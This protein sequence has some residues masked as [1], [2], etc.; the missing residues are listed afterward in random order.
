MVLFYQSAESK[1]PR[2][3]S[4]MRLPFKLELLSAYV[5]F[6]A[7]VQKYIY[8]PPDFAILTLELPEVLRKHIQFFL[9]TYFTHSF[10]FSCHNDLEHS[11]LSYLWGTVKCSYQLAHGFVEKAAS[12]LNFRR[13]IYQKPHF[14]TSAPE[15]FVLML[16][17]TMETDY[18]VLNNVLI[19][20]SYYSK[21]RLMQL[22]L[23]KGAGDLRNAFKASY[24]SGDIGLRKRVTTFKRSENYNLFVDTR[25]HKLYHHLVNIEKPWSEAFDIWQLLFHRLADYRRAE[26]AFDRNYCLKNCFCRNVSDLSIPVSLWKGQIFRLICQLSLEDLFHYLSDIPTWKIPSIVVTC[27]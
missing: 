22:C 6:Q 9:S 12:S 13:V 11:C 26:R 8:T 21:T 15:S 5:I 27:E 23:H 17:E 19:L 10:P 14:F 18:I 7:I 16:V 2:H 24:I 3:H 20:A 25:E 4:V 1:P